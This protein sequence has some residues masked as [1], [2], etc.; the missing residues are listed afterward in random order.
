[1]WVGL[2]HLF[3]GGPPLP[4]VR[5][6]AG[7]GPRGHRRQNPHTHPKHPINLK[8]QQQCV[9]VVASVLHKRDPQLLPLLTKTKDNSQQRISWL[10]QR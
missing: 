7:G 4:P 6:L 10:P 5:G 8:K 3:A 2:W 9:M 1:M